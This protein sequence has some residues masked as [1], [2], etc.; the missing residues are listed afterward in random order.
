M[1]PLTTL[2]ALSVGAMLV[3]YALEPRSAGFVLAFA[4]ACLAS[5][6]T[7]SPIPSASS[8]GAACSTACGRSS[9][10]ARRPARRRQLATEK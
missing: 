9:T 6:V 4:A 7:R 5:R 3:F 2:G 10:T 8:R 1:D